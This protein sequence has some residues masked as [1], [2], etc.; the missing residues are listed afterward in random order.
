MKTVTIKYFDKDEQ[1]ICNYKYAYPTDK[2]LLEI[3]PE[4]KEIIPQK[5]Q[6]WTRVKGKLLAKEMIPYFKKCNE[7][8]DDLKIAFW[9]EAYRHCAGRF[10]EVI[11]Q[12]KR[13]RRL[14]A[15]IYVP[16]NFEDW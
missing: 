14:E 15:M 6:D 7:L 10:N 9:K 12:I 5:I 2:E 13:L 8:K 4:A 3:F 16:E 1:A 11:K